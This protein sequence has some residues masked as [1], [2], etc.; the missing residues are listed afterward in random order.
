MQVKYLGSP[1]L[2]FNQLQ[3]RTIEPSVGKY[4][5]WTIFKGTPDAP[6]VVLDASGI[7]NTVLGW[8]AIQPEGIELV[9]GDRID[10]VCGTIRIDIEAYEQHR[11]DDIEKNGTS[12]MADFSALLVDPKSNDSITG[13]G[14]VVEL[15][16]VNR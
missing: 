4:S 6:E 7:D 9:A 14:C 12:T 8:V 5:N 13:S 15:V 11:L 16:H 2:G 1:S 10:L 3:R